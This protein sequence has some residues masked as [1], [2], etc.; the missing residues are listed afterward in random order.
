MQG[1]EDE[2]EESVVAKI[3]NIIRSTED[4]ASKKE[5]PAK[6]AIIQSTEEVSQGKEKE[7]SVEQVI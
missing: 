7:E 3:P 5:S 4:T 6:P 2:G 1:S